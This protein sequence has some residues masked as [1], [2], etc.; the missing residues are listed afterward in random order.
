VPAVWLSV[1]SWFDI[2]AVVTRG[3]VGEREEREP[4]LLVMA[5]IDVIDVDNR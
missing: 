4:S 2:L 5:Q 1:A 3:D